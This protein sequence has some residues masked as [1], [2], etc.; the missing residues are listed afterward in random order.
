MLSENESK[1]VL[2]RLK[3]IEGQ[4]SGIHRMV[5]KDSYCVD[6]LNQISAIQSALNQVG[7]IILGQHVRTCVQEAF[8]SG[9]EAERR[10]KTEELLEI[11]AKM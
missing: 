4:V 1:R 3:R 10:Q 6:I 2:A 5:E 9:S 8:K 11:I 7:K